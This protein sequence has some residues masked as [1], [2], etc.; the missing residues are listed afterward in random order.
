MPT[1]GPGGLAGVGP[2]AADE[3][4][5]VHPAD[6]LGDDRQGQVRGQQEDGDL[7]QT[8]AG[9][10]FHGRVAGE[11]AE[12]AHEVTGRHFRLRRQAVKGPGSGKIRPQAG[13]GRHHH[14][15]G[16]AAGDGPGAD[17]RG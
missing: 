12:Q 7:L 5:G 14:W 4:G 1:V 10:P 2:E 8:L 3:M 17:G 15:V 9:Q 6:P 11:T 13:N 16:G